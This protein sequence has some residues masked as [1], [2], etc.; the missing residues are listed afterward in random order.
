MDVRVRPPLR[1]DS[2]AESIP[3]KD[4][5]CKINTMRIAIHCCTSAHLPKIKEFDC[6]MYN[7]IIKGIHNLFK[8]IK[9]NIAL[10]ISCR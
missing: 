6:S 7:L 4:T 3:L 2:I 9:V 10:I 5:I 8:I 1:A